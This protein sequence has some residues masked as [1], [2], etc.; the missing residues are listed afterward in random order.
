MKSTMASTPASAALYQ[1]HDDW[2]EPDRGNK[3][4]VLY[5]HQQRKNLSPQHRQTCGVLHEKS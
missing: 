1:S 3:S 5:V 4:P 2:E